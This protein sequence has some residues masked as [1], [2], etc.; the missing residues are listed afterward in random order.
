MFKILDTE[1]RNINSYQI[2]TKSTKEILSI[3]NSE[4][5]LVAF[6]VEKAI[7]EISYLVDDIV[8]S[9][10]KGGRLFY[11]G[12]GTSGRLGVLDAS[13]CNPTFGVDRTLVQGIIA[14]GEKALTQSIESA[15]DNKEASIDE[16]KRRGFSQKDVLVGIT[17]S[18][19]APYVV[20]ALSYAKE[21]G[22]VVGAIACNKESK[23]FENA[24][25]KI[26]LSVGPE[27]ITGSTRMKSGTAQ[28]LVLNML[29]TTT[30]I[31]LGKVYNNYMID[32]RPVN[33]KLVQRSI[34][35]IQDITGLDKEKSEDY[36]LRSDKNVRLAV[37]MALFN[38]DKNKAKLL[39][40]E[41]NNNINNIIN[42]L[43]HKE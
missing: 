7:N 27:I 3:I 5:K 26:Y 35:L 12:A 6:A 28:K 29:T 37:V 17:A 43:K 8:D 13:E 21:I 38:I 16:L 24:H 32:L 36:F 19:S 15:E 11:I 40:K 1:K 25:H 2:D 10:K 4:D 34:R 39:L 33:A 20:S 9:M 22:A 42:A 14:G 41:N 30:M 31:K 23:V 18:G